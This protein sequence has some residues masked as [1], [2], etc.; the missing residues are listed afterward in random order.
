MRL[1]GNARRVVHLER[2]RN[3][4]PPACPRWAATIARSFKSFSSDPVAMARCVQFREYN[5]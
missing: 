5:V 3:H 1:S 4:F 2:G